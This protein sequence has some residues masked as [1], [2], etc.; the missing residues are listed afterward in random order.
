MRAPAVSIRCCAQTSP[1]LPTS[2]TVWSKGRL[3]GNSALDFYPVFP[4]SRAGWF[5]PTPEGEQLMPVLTCLGPFHAESY[6]G[7]AGRSLPDGE[8]ADQSNRRTLA[9][10]A[11]QAKTSEQA[12]A[13]LEE[14]RLELRGPDG[15]VIPAEWIGVRDTE[16]LLA[17]PEL[18][19]DQA[20]WDVDDPRTAEPPDE[21]SAGLIELGLDEE[22]IKA[23]AELLEAEFAEAVVEPWDDPVLPRY[24]IFVE[25]RDPADVPVSDRWKHEM[26]SADDGS[27]GVDQS[28]D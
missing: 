4:T 3:L 15:R 19:D 27:S 20:P 9:R 12:G 7:M 25:L 28:R 22:S 13:A 24:Q 1:E 10:R 6:R 8:P 26:T 2:Y 17:L 11:L 18:D 23:D 14:L 16:F 21:F 5:E